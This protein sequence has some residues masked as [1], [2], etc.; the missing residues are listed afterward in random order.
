LTDLWNIAVSFMLR[1]DFGASKPYVFS[2]N[3]SL[4]S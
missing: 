4:Q 2:A 1:Q 3:D